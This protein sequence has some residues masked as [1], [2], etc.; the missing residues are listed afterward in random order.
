MFVVKAFRMHQR[1][2]VSIRLI[3]VDMTP[4]KRFAKL[5][6]DGS[7]QYCLPYNKKIPISQVKRR[8]PRN[9]VVHCAITNTGPAHENTVVISPILI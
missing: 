3:N 7:I 5:C 1:Q 4:E 6:L 8:S 2:L 9:G